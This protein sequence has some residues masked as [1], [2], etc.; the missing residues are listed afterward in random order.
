MMSAPHEPGSPLLA[1]AD[2]ASEPERFPDA[3]TLALRVHQ[4]RGA[5]GLDVTVGHA[6]TGGPAFPAVLIWRSAPR[7]FLA[8]ACGPGADT[9]SQLLAALSR[10][11]RARAA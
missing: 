4:L 2:G 5:A 3:D 10:T 8:V 6:S 11:A 1:V 7:A 9:P